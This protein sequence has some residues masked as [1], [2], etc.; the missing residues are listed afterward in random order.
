M[1]NPENVSLFNNFPIFF[2]SVGFVH[3]YQICSDKL[4]ENFQGLIKLCI[5][6]RE[7]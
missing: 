4:K 3:F 7:P 2:I 6:K 5:F 1:S